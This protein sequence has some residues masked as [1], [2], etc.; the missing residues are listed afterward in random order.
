MVRAVDKKPVR[1]EFYKSHHADGDTPQK[2]QTAKNKE[3]NRAIG[4]AND[5]G[6]LMVREIE[7]VQYARTETPE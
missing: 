7:D 3:F 5:A 1:A 2:R 6:L 4:D